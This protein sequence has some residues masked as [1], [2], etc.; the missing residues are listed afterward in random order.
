[1]PANT[2]SSEA[3]GTLD[4]DERLLSRIF[5]IGLACRSAHLVLP[6]EGGTLPSSSQ[7]CGNACEKTVRLSRRGPGDRLVVSYKNL[8]PF[9]QGMA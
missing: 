4:E 8:L 5:A 1:M 2:V 9:S 7:M 6:M 3:L